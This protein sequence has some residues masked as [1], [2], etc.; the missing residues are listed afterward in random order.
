MK[1]KTLIFGVVIIIIILAAIAVRFVAG[2]DEDTWLCEDGHWIM[3]GNP[4]SS[5]PTRA[6]K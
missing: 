6:C 3:H 2:G 5:M 4:T 1:N